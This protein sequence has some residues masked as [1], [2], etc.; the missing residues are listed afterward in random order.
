VTGFSSPDDLTVS[1]A[2]RSR[3]ST[4]IGGH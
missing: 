1:F 3:A 2:A 4:I